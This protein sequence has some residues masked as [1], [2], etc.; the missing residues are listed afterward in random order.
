MLDVIKRIIQQRAGNTVFAEYYRSRL[1][2][3]R[4]VIEEEATVYMSSLLPLY[5][6]NTQDKKESK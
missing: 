4:N 3:I 6:W 5:D 2:A 1:V